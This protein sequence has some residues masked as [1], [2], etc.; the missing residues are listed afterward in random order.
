MQ[1]KSK[2]ISFV[3]AVALSCMQRAASRMAKETQEDYLNHLY[4]QVK[5]RPLR[6]GELNLLP[7]DSLPGFANTVRC[8]PESEEGIYGRITAIARVKKFP[9]LSCAIFSLQ[10]NLSSRLHH[11]L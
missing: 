6:E 9:I 2:Y 1:W 7:D 3:V 8:I 5:D 4:L 11:V 10:C